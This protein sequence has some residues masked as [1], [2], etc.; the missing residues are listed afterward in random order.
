MP[1]EKVEWFQRKFEEKE[2]LKEVVFN[3]DAKKSSKRI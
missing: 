3:L 2:L 1:A